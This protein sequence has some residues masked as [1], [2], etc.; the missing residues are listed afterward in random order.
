M[1][2]KGLIMPAALAAALLAP[3]AALACASCGCTLNS[4]W[5]SQGLAF[6]PGLQLDLRYDY[7][8][9]NDLRS[10]THG[11]DRSSIALPTDREIEVMTR[12]NYVTLGL[13][14]SPNE[15]WGFSAQVPYI[16]RFHTTV[17][18]GETDISSSNTR[19]LGDV[20]IM[21]RYQGF[22]ASRNVGLQFGLKL[23]TG[24]FHD[25][26]RTGPE[27]GGL[28]DRGLQAG[29][30][31]TDALIGAY[32][33]GNWDYFVQGLVEAPFAARQDYRPGIAF[34]VNAGIHYVGF[35]SITP[36][37]Q[38]SAKTSGPDKGL[39]ADT[40][41]SGGTLVYLGAGGTLNITR[42]VRLYAFAQVPVYQDVN[43]YQ[44]A[45]RWVL[46]TGLHLSL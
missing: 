7:L 29:T 13:D 20:K 37:I 18:E 11:I 35:D 30:G 42:Q 17:A 3:G 4:D 10:G 24:S 38:I 43:G 15:S 26:F 2:T 45:P 41:N 27:A 25:V 23:P 14:Y 31:T 9:Q 40:E 12:N 46:T 22:T 34:N 32:A 21:A 8:N 5:V 39:E 44:L 28:I 6:K 1:S 33:F 36:Q 19:D 16:D